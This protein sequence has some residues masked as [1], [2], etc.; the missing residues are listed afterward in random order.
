MRLFRGSGLV[1]LGDDDRNDD[2]HDDDEK[3][4]EQ[5]PPL[6]A[7]PA[8]CL[9]DCAAD[10]G[11]RLDDVVVNLLALLLDVGD[12]GFLLLHNLVQVLE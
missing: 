2:D 10:L 4:D 12:E 6:L 1:D 9:F 11:V 7:V 5:A 8:T 3:H